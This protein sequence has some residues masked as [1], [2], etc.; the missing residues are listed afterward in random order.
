MNS[1]TVRS[2]PRLTRGPA[3]APA[4]PPPVSIFPTRAIESAKTDEAGLPGGCGLTG[5]LA[6]LAVLIH[7]LTRRRVRGPSRSGGSA[8]PYVDSKG[9]PGPAQ[10]TDGTSSDLHS[11]RGR[12]ARK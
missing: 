10:N 9:R 7:R 11:W 3:P 12:R 1:R 8:M 6:I 2:E 4:S 5:W